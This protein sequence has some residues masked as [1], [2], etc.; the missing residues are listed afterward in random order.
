[1]KV[2]LKE[3]LVENDFLFIHKLTKHKIE[4]ALLISTDKFRS[5]FE[6]IFA[7]LEKLNKLPKS[8]I[9]KNQKFILV[10][11]KKESSLIHS[12]W[13]N[14][15]YEFKKKSYFTRFYKLNG[16]SW[17]KLEIIPL[18]ENI[19][20]LND[21]ELKKLILETTDFFANI[22]KWVE[23][24]FLPYHMQEWEIL[25]PLKTFFENQ[26]LIHKYYKI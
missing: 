26:D 1:M 18:V 13:H 12:E 15:L 2:K 4:I 6:K 17:F 10:E 5:N 23:K 16:K 19:S 20:N 22:T 8:C 24:S 21:E 14:W 9:W 7:N 11:M 3:L 25:L